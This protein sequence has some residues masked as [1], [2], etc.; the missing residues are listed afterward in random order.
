MLHPKQA[1]AEVWV[2]LEQVRVENV[3]LRKALTKLVALLDADDPVTVGC[4]CTDTGYGPLVCPWCQARQAL[5]KAERRS[6]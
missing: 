2:E 3:R 5:A 1:Y 6:I 4:H